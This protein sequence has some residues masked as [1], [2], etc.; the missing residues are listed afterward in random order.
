[1][2]HFVFLL[3]NVFSAQISRKQYKLDGWNFFK[4]QKLM[5]LENFFKKCKTFDVV[6]M[7]VRVELHSSWAFLN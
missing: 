3:Q 6:H 2:I 7:Q 4:I 5:T 1:M